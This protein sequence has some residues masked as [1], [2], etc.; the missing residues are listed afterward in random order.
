[1]S[2][3]FNNSSTIL[4]VISGEVEF[5]NENIGTILASAMEGS[6]INKDTKE[7]NKYK[8]TEEE[9]NL[10]FEQLVAVPIKDLADVND[11]SYNTIEQMFEKDNSEME[12]PIESEFSQF[13]NK[14]SNR[15]KKYT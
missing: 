15:P 14:Y 1:M 2:Y 11:T 10:I 12:N 3:D 5:G 9:V 8:I 6:E 13:G 7:A 4:K